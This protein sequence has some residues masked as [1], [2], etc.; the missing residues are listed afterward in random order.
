MKTP[1]R[2][3]RRTLTCEH[4]RGIL[5]KAAIG[6]YPAGIRVGARQVLPRQEAQQLTPVPEVRRCDLRNL[7]VTE[8]LAEILARNFPAADRIAVAF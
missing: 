4:A 7:L 3:L 8:R 1:V 2:S 6:V 5:T